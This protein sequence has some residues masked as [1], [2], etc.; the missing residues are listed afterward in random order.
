MALVQQCEISSYS[1]PLPQAVNAHRDV[2]E[3]FGWHIRIQLADGQVGMGDVAPWPGFGVQ[4][5]RVQ[6]EI[7]ALPRRLSD[8]EINLAER[9]S[10]FVDGLDLSDI[11]SGGLEAA[12][13]DLAAQG[14]GV[15][16]ATHL[17]R[18]AADTIPV[19]ALVDD[20]DAV[21]G[22]IHKG[23]TTLKLKVGGDL[24]QDLDRVKAVRSIA[25]T[26]RLRLDANGRWDRHQALAFIRKVGDLENLVFEQ[27]ADPQDVDA[28]AWLKQSTGAY[29]AADESVITDHERLVQDSAVDELVLKPMFL[30]GLLRA[31]RL[32]ETARLAGKAV[33]VT[34]ALESE[35]GRLGAQALAAGFTSDGV[36]GVCL[37][38]QRIQD[39]RIHTAV[40]PGLGRAPS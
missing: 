22:L 18:E 14:S 30:G 20:A 23:L 37:A 16:L 32:G 8:T 34:H 29:L 12:L 21:E 26:Q 24:T 38:G 3:R 2:G 35:V 17:F 1:R 5:S 27:L 33:C 25:P 13:L 36:H 9:L 15:S 19:H 6:N 28:F 31:R 40:S 4:A 39:G 7:S 10:D 11:V